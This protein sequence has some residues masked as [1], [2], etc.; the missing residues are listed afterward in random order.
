MSSKRPCLRTDIRGRGR[1]QADIL[2]DR[3]LPAGQGKQ[4][5]PSRVYQLLSVAILLG[6]IILA[7]LYRIPGVLI[8]ENIACSSFL[9]PLYLSVYLTVEYRRYARR[10][11]VVKSIPSF[12]PSL[13][14]SSFYSRVFTAKPPDAILNKGTPKRYL[15]T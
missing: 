14:L 12:P 6:V 7:A 2:E 5:T 1:R 4:T 11:A 3:G 15:I 13:F 8:G 9:V 10:H